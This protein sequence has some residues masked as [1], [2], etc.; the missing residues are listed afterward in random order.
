MIIMT[1]QIFYNFDY[2]LS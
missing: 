2:N 1:D